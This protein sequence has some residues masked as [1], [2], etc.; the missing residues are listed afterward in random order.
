VKRLTA[1]AHDD[2]ELLE[3]RERDRQAVVELFDRFGGHLVS[4]G[5]A[6]NLLGVTR[7][8]VYTLGKRGDLRVFRSEEQGHGGDGPTWVYIPLA[9]VEAYADRVGRPLPRWSRSSGS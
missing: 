8:T 9:D 3:L 7:Q 4:P 5:A 2:P 6:A 1:R